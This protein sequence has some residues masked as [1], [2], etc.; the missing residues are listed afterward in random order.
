MS[1]PN[2][3][4]GPKFRATKGNRLIPQKHYG[5]AVYNFSTKTVFETLRRLRNAGQAHNSP[6]RTP[7]F[8]NGSIQM[9]NNVARRTARS[10]ARPIFTLSSN[11]VASPTTGWPP[12][13]RRTAPFHKVCFAPYVSRRAER[14]RRRAFGAGYRKCVTKDRCEDEPVRSR[15]QAVADAQM[16][17][18]IGELE[19]RDRKQAVLLL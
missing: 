10:G 13:T 6:E 4:S 2:A 16:H 17:V 5:G 9:K 12:K 1:T 19:I 15:R 11:S 3:E 8:A 14:K 7:D 18:K